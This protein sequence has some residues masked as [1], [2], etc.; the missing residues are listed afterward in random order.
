M[1]GEKGL[2]VVG[3]RGGRKGGGGTLVVFER[4]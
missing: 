2:M 4:L 3:G 1:V